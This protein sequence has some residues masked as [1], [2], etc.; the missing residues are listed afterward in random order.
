MN[1]PK[2]NVDRILNELSAQIADLTKQLAVS[3]EEAR[4]YK[5]LYESIDKESDE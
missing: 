4:T 1:E 5:E 2:L 3:R